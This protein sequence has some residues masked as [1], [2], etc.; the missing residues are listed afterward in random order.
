MRKKA[1]KIYI[2]EKYYEELK[3][4]AEKEG[5]TVPKV[6]GK[7]IAESLGDGETL[8]DRVKDLEAKYEQLVKEVGRMEKDLA[9]LQKILR[10]YRVARR[11]NINQE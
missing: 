8:T 4:I 2:E 10:D 6:I 9:L 3:K 11:S 7:I 5:L 1:V